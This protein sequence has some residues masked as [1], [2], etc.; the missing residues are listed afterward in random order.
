ML[1]R[2]EERRRIAAA[3][4]AIRRA[5]RE[6]SA[7][8]VDELGP[9]MRAWQEV[10]QAAESAHGLWQRL[11]RAE[12]ETRQRLEAALKL[13]R[14]ELV[15]AAWAEVEEAR[16]QYP[17]LIAAEAGDA[18]ADEIL[19]LTCMVSGLPVFK[20]DEIYGD[21]DLGFVVLKRAVK[22]VDESWRA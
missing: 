4:S 18:D 8:S 10:R 16:R 2:L 20:G 14:R 1:D 7:A 9:L 5:A 13:Y 15:S 19:P 3:I 22:L 17:D 12:E 6:M 11:A 21:A